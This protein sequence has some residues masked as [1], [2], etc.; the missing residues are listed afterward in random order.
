MDSAKS[1]LYDWI[2]RRY[3]GA[4]HPDTA[5]QDDVYLCI[6]FLAKRGYKI[7]RSDD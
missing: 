4:V 2:A 1:A 3:Y 7:V 6:E 5:V